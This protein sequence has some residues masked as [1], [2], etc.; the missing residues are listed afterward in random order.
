MKKRSIAALAALALTS[1][2]FGQARLDLAKPD[3]ALKATQKM[4][5]SLEDGKT[6]VYWW[7]GGA[8]SRSPGERDRHLFDVEGFNIRQCKNFSDPERGHG[9]RSVS[10]EIML[11]LDAET[12]AVLRRWK[13]PWTGAEVAVIHV[14]NDPVNMR[15][16]MYGLSEEGKPHRFEGTFKKG[17]VWTSGEVPLFYKNPLGGEYQE[18]VGGSYHAIE[19]LNS[20]AYEEDLLDASKPTLDDETLSW[21]RVSEWLPWMEMGDRPGMMVFST[22]GKRVRSFDALSDVLKN[23][24][25]ANYPTYSAP[26]PTDDTRPNETSWSHFKK[27]LDARKKASGRE[28]R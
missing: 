28:S 20:F 3:E 21:A 23:E 14:A 2:A 8:F 17:R 10:R 22:V 25:R 12:G 24:V 1:P 27:V 13:N 15:A 9:F 19:M 7:K 18:Y 26:P 4:T 11:Y 5:C 6:I 16:P